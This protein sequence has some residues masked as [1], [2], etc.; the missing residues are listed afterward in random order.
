MS[1]QMSVVIQYG[2]TMSVLKFS[3]RDL[4]WLVALV[5]LGCGWWVEYCKGI[6]AR[7]QLRD[8]GLLKESLRSQADREGHLLSSIAD[9]LPK[10]FELAH[11]VDGWELRNMK[12]ANTD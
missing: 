2:E 3:L 4:F 12:S 7:E 1:V 11:T 5:A 10:G 8:Y 6:S 9:H